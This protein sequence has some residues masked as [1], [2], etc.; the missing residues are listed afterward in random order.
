VRRR[1]AAK[2]MRSEGNAPSRAQIK[3]VIFSYIVS[4]IL[5][6]KNEPKSLKRFRRVQ[7]LGII[8]LTQVGG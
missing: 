5:L 4:F 8:P 6:R 2:P 1:K 7:K 3:T